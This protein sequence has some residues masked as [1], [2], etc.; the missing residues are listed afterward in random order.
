MRKMRNKYTT[1]KVIRHL[2]AFNPIERSE[3]LWEYF[4]ID[5]PD[6]QFPKDNDIQYAFVLGWHNEFGTVD[7]NELTKRAVTDTTNLDE[8]AA[9]EGW[10]WIND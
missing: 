1:V 4:V 8:V 9:P 5:D 6:M 3:P 10:E 7:M 2:N